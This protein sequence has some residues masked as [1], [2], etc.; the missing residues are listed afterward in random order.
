MNKYLF[1]Y[2]YIYI[3]HTYLL[4]LTLLAVLWSTATIESWYRRENTLQFQWGMTRYTATEMPRPGFQGKLE[5]SRMNG[6][7][8]E[9]IP[10]QLWYIVRIMLSM[11]GI[12]GCIS[13]VI[14]VVIGIWTLKKRTA[15]DNMSVL[16]GMLNAVQI[17]VSS[18]RPS[19]YIYS[20]FISNSFLKCVVYLLLYY[21][22]ACIR[23]C[24]CKTTTCVHLKKKKK[25]IYIY[26]YVYIYFLNVD[27]FGSSYNCCCRCV[28]IFNYVYIY[29]A[30]WLNEME[31]HRL[32]E[33]W[34]NH[35]V[36]K[37]VFFLIINSFNS[38]F[39]L[40]FVQDFSSHRECLAAVRIQLVTLFLSMIF[41]QNAMEVFIPKMMVLRFFHKTNS[42]FYQ[43]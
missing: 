24:A 30:F 25:N 1:I 38:L 4:V 37:R 18:S 31:G 3:Y 13:C 26:V 19:F 16:V 33:E 40:A 22:R 28:C 23:T 12:I 10:S 20:L 36:V 39:Y 34:Y 9:V 29:L 41:I 21:A 15:N 32:E 27:L 14:A 5:L 43:S 17:T 7:I 6:E 8:V 2:L 11:S 42:F 35:L